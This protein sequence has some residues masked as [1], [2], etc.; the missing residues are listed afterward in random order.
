MIVYLNNLIGIHEKFIKQMKK[1]Q[2][3]R[4]KKMRCVK[5]EKYENARVNRTMRIIAK[6]TRLLE[7]FESINEILPT[8][9]LSSS[10]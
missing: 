2:L 5:R 10:Q 1:R 9:F 3:Q 4:R 7:R 8:P 6:I